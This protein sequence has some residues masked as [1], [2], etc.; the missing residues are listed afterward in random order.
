MHNCRL[1]QAAPSEI[2]VQPKNMHFRGSQMYCYGTSTCFGLSVL[3]RGTLFVGCT[4]IS[5]FGIH[6]ENVSQICSQTV[7]VMTLPLTV[8]TPSHRP[9]LT[10]RLRRYVRILSWCGFRLW[11]GR[12]F[13]RDS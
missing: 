7:A 4:F 9:L 10:S 3:F 8:V 2:T 12:A 13:V 5:Y 6:G 1:E 11:T